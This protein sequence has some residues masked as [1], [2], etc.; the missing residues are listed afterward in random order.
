VWVPED[1]EVVYAE[2]ATSVLA[3]V[4]TWCSVRSPQALVLTDEGYSNPVA[5][6]GLDEAAVEAALIGAV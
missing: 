3:A 2:A 4:A 1:H 6:E 5:L